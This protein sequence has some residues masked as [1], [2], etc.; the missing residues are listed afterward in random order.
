MNKGA[1][2]RI[3]NMQPIHHDIHSR[4]KIRQQEDKITIQNGANENFTES[5]RLQSLDRKRNDI[6]QE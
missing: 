1:K 3:Y 2:L 4:S 6:G 5:C